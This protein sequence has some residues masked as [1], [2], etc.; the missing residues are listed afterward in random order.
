MKEIV[1]FEDK[2]LTTQLIKYLESEKSIK[3]TNILEKKSSQCFPDIFY[4]DELCK[5]K[6]KF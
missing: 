5:K 1:G 6:Y 4:N 3:D 2:E